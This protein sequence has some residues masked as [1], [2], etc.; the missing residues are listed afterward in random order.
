MKPGYQSTEFIT[1]IVLIIGAVVLL[2]LG[3]FTKEDLPVLLTVSGLM[4]T[5]NIS[6]GIAKQ[7][8]D[9]WDVVTNRHR[10]PAK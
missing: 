3:V 6:R 8:Y 10:P 2:A 1:T 9:S 5:Y 7:G 4:G